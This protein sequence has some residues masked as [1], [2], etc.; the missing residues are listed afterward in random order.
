M[1]AVNV[2]SSFGELDEESPVASRMVGAANATK[3]TDLTRCIVD[4][5]RPL[6]RVRVVG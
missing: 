6:C 1:D 5:L 3:S 4:A 2:S